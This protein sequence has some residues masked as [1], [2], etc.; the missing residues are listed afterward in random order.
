MMSEVPPVPMSFTPQFDEP[1]VL[2]RE[3]PDADWALPAAPTEPTKHARTAGA[4]AP[5]QLVSLP[6]PAVI[7][8]VKS[9]PA[10]YTPLSSVST[11][12]T[13]PSP[14]PATAAAA[15]LLELPGPAER[16]AMT[17][18]FL[19]SEGGSGSVRAAQQ[20]LDAA[21]ADI[22]AL[23]HALGVLRAQQRAALGACDAV[24]LQ[25]LGA[26]AAEAAGCLQRV[27][28]RLSALEHAHLL[29]PDELH[30]VTELR[31][32]AG[33][34]AAQAD[35]YRCEAHAA[36]AGRAPSAAEA[37]RLV[38]TAQPFPLV[39]SKG[40][41]ADAPLDVTLLTGA[42]YDLPVCCGGGGCGS[43][44][45]GD[46]TRIIEHIVPVIVPCTP[47]KS[48]AQNIVAITAEE[49]V[50][51]TA[52]TRLTLRT[53]NGSRMV[54]VTLRIAATFNDSSSGSSNLITLESDSTHPFIVITN[55]NQYEESNGS[56]L[57][58]LAFGAG[59]ETPWPRFAN[60]LQRHFLQTT[61]QDG[62]APVGPAA[63]HCGGGTGAG[64]PS[65]TVSGA[66][67]SAAALAAALTPEDLPVRALAARELAY[68]HARFFGGRAAV[69]AAQ[70]DAFWAW[71]G[72][73]LQ[74]MRTT[75]QICGL[76][77]DGLLW[78]CVP[79][80][81]IERA[82][83]PLP[84][85]AFV[86]RV[87]ERHPGQFAIA[88]RTP[89]P[90]AVKHYLVRPEEIS[91]QKTL[92]DFLHDTPGLAVVVRVLH[93]DFGPALDPPPAL[94]QP[95][96]IPLPKSEALEKFLSKREPVTLVGYE[97]SLAPTSAAL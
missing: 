50:P 13:P 15:V 34:A 72:K 94:P 96:Y 86:V 58:H 81:D 9:E 95:L 30:A 3:Q 59:A 24:A 70:F 47:S 18:R 16:A 62:S 5:P 65:G 48:A 91:T 46:T 79:R 38:V 37:L 28:E 36:L 77:R 25:A 69:G 56:L 83:A 29:L 78:A 66:P 73:L 88:Y 35:V 41:H 32:R 90:G 42:A 11:P 61:R 1:G 6:V 57:R 52:T 54:P 45:E 89:A 4:T 44:D 63:I 71:F 64:A 80:A 43:E 19:G 68:V 21:A 85:G 26:Q 33:V 12:P 67:A 31:A 23:E 93:H 55:E 82:L 49:R 87:S 53:T 97:P 92:P 75:R 84:A 14:P 60:A 17:E 8:S 74:R 76:W 39:L 40:K 20:V 27:R 2:K 51:G 22:G 7:S 10:P